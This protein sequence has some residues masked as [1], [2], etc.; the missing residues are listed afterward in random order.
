MTAGDPIA[1][2]GLST[3]LVADAC[4]RC[5]VPLRAAPA[6]IRRVGAGMLVGG[7]ALPAR[8]YGSV[9]VFLEAF[10]HA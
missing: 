4:L 2:S 9:D 6:G 10:G 5:G 1:A 3:P 8:H 7:H